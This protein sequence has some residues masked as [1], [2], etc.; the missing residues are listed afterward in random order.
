LSR[1]LGIDLGSRRIGLAVADAASG[2]IRPLA[3]LR[4]AS[5]ERD[6]ATLLRVVDEQRIDELVLGLPRNMDGSEG[7]Q[8]AQT[9]RWADEVASCLGLPLSYRDE[10]LTTEQAESRRGRLRR[11]GAGGP[12]SAG[13]RSAHRAS[14][15]REAAALIVQA[16]LDARAGLTRG[17]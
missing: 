9:R 3:T 1:L 13:A 17:G 4:R 11:G 5:P 16:E 14:V 10:R 8:A 7:A 15:D 2:S 12:P 6:A